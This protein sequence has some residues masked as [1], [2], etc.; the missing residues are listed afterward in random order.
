MAKRA[1]P[2]TDPK[3]TRAKENAEKVFAP[4]KKGDK[5][6]TQRIIAD[7]ARDADGQRWLAL[8][9]S[10]ER[11]YEKELANIRAKKQAAKSKLDK[12]YVD[13]A[14]ALKT[15]GVTKQVLHELYEWSRKDPKELIAHFQALA[16]IAR[17]GGMAIGQQM[18][19]FPEAVKS[20]EDA[21][22]KAKMQGRQCSATGGSSIDNPYHAGSPLGQSWLEGYSDDQAKLVPGANGGSAAAH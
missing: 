20:P 8:I 21:V 1:S 11:D 4:K 18:V 3:K 10:A 9:T 17:A 14:D 6:N 7:L 13:G 15:R 19:L 12:L 16:W 22:E 5:S 2:Q